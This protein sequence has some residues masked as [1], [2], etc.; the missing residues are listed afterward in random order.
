MLQCLVKG[1]YAYGYLK[2]EIGVHR[3]VRISPFD[4][5]KRRHTSFASVFS[6]PEVDDNIDIEIN[7][8][9]LRIDTYRAQ[10]A[11]GQHVN[12]TDS[13]VRITHTPTGIVVQCQNERSQ[14]KN[15][16]RAMKILKARLFE[17]YKKKQEEEKQKEENQKKAI[18]WGS[19]IRS[20]VFHPYNMVKDHRS[21]FETGNVEG[22]MDGNIQDFIISVLKWSIKN[23]MKLNNNKLENKNNNSEKKTRREFIKKL[24]KTSLLASSIGIFN[25]NDIYSKIKGKCLLIPMDETASNHLKAYGLCYW[26]LDKKMP[27]EWLLNYRG[28]SFIVPDTE[29]V[30]NKALINNISFTAID[31]D[32]RTSIYTEIAYENMLKIDLNKAP[33]IAVYA[34]P[35]NQPWDD[36][37]TLILEY[38]NIPY[39]IIWDK[40]IQDG[41]LKDYDWLHLHHE[42]FTGQFGKFYATYRNARW[43]KEMVVEFNKCAKE[44]GYNSVQAHK[45]ETCRLIK[46]FVGKGGFLFAMCSA[47]ETLDI[48]LSVYGIPIVPIEIGGI[49]NDKDAQKKIDYSKTFAFTDYILNMD[50]REYKFSNINVDTIEEGIYTKKD[51]FGLFD[52]SAKVDPIPTILCQNHTRTIKGFLGQTTAF[53][54]ET[55]KESVIIMGQTPN[56]HRVR[57]LYGDHGKGFFT[58]YSGHDPED[59]IHRLGD[60]PT[61]LAQYP[62][63]PGYRLILNNILFPSTKKKKRKT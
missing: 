47:T 45:A 10:G 41:K 44:A 60:P 35:T 13:A 40:E 26:V 50:P 6:F 2:S 23:Q 31:T 30:R 61:N 15:K 17:Y 46:E 63:S 36:A 54:K 55:I 42:D 39:D 16:D 18:A 4:S 32:E 14:H 58:Y 38:S 11:G 48:A 49:P 24:G 57:Y 59:Y 37:V 56:T 34:P 62:N 8:T 28:G 1:E 25:L 51:Y 43:Y 5:N 27:A 53:T 52:F 21:N 19:Q 29:E 20:Y 9:D 7:T 22:V 3:L 33:K 12:T